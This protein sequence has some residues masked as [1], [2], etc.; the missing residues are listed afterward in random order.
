M[1]LVE[2]QLPR[3]R[4]TQDYLTEFGGAVNND[5]WVVNTPA[6]TSEDTDLSS[7]TPEQAE[8]TLEYFVACG[9]RLT[10]MTK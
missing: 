6:L 9:D 3:Y 4:L 8:A 2:E 1:S 7:L 5:Q 10:Q